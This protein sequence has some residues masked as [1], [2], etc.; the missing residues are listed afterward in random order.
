MAPSPFVDTILGPEVATLLDVK[1][2]GSGR[3]LQL[4]VPA[5]RRYRHPTLALG[6]S[7]ENRYQCVDD[8]FQQLMACTN[9]TTTEYQLREPLTKARKSGTTATRT[10]I[11][12]ILVPRVGLYSR[13]NN[14]KNNSSSSSNNGDDNNSSINTNYNNNKNSGAGSVPLKKQWRSYSLKWN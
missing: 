6:S 5:G 3:G 9:T 10:P 2:R 8:L 13:P 4:Q 11:K 1:F 14:N 12:H 7:I